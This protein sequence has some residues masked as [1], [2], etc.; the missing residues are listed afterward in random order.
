MARDFQ[1]FTEALVRVR[2]GAHLSGV[3]STV[4]DLGLAEKPITIRPNWVHRDIHYDD[5][6]PNVPPEVMWMLA[7]VQISMRL[8]HYD[9]LIL[10]TCMIEAEAGGSAFSAAAVAAATR[11]A[12]TLAPAGSLMGNNL[13]LF[14][15]GNH[16]ISMS[17]VPAI[18]PLGNQ[19]PYRFPSC[20]LTGPA[21]VLPL[22]TEKTLAEVTWRAIPYTPYPLATSLVFTSGTSGT[23]GMQMLGGGGA[24]YTAVYGEPL[25]SGAILWDRN[26]QF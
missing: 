23:P 24:T 15:S 22:G 21:V 16:Y 25:S 9:Q 26:Y 13:P 7:D 14:A 4:T 19:L 3:M 5:F 2:G 17:I 11:F 12:G 8:V 10:D 1:I 6:G 18:G 20:Y